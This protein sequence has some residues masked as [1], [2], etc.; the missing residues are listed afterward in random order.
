MRKDSDKKNS[1]HL[2]GVIQLLPLLLISI[3]VLGGF[4]VFSSGS[5]D[6]EKTRSAVLSKSDEGEGETKQ[7]RKMQINEIRI[8]TRQEKRRERVETYR[9]N[10][11]VHLEK[12]DGG[13]VFRVGEGE[14]EEFEEGD[15]I[16]I[17]EGEETDFQIKTRKDKFSIEKS[18]IRARTH[19]P[20]SVNSETNELTVTTPAGTKTVTVLPNSAV[21]NMLRVGF[22]DVVLG[23]EGEGEG[24]ATPGPTEIEGEE[25]GEATPSSTEIEEGIAE[26]EETIDLAEEDGQLVY[27]IRGVKKKRFLGLFYINVP[28]T[29]VVS[30]ETGE[31]VLIDQTFLA[32]VL[33]FAS[34]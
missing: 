15:G 6:L 5:Q 23:E 21:E 12:K 8:R 9:N 18:G 11:R 16:E 27:K 10:V 28:R 17:G 25:G 32:K 7:E 2:L 30:A 4:A 3:L 1:F 33:D 29:A 22:L 31:L 24:E 34:F 19:F 20:L 13:S 26:E 14:E